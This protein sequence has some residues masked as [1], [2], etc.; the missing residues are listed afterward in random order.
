MNQIPLQKP[1][2]SEAVEQ[3]LIKEGV[4]FS[5]IRDFLDY[6]KKNPDVWRYFEAACMELMLRGIKKYGAKSIVEKVRWD[7]SIE[8]K[9]EFKINNDYTAYFIRAFLVKHPNAKEIFT[10][11]KVHG[12]RKAA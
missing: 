4:P 8:R 2:L 11:K 5:T 10:T 7:I 12:L 9:G 1:K 3:S 6:W